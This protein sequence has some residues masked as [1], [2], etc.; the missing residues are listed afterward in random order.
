M[1]CDSKQHVTMKI[2]VTQL[3][4][5][6][7]KYRAIVITCNHEFLLGLAPYISQVQLSFSNYQM[8]DLKKKK[9]KP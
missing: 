3:S 6:S 5:H 1:K 8:P 9:K 7:V 2:E 4:E